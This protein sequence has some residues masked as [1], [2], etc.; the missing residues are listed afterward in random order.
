MRVLDLFESVVGLDRIFADA[1]KMKLND[2]LD[3]HVGELLPEHLKF[4]KKPAHTVHD[5][6]DPNSLDPSEWDDWDDAFMGDSKAKIADIEK[7]FK[8]GTK[9]PPILVNGTPREK[10]QPQVQDG[11]HRTAAAIKAKVKVPVIYT[12][13]TLIRIWKE[14]N[15]NKESVKVLRAQYGEHLK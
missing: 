12:I 10:Y 2:F 8:S 9:V 1:K 11:H 5:S 6:L 15:H 7:K 14:A 4:G 3:K 13:E